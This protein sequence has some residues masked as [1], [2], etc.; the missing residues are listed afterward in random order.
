MFEKNTISQS[1]IDAVNNVLENSNSVL[2]EKVDVKKR[3][4]DTLAG[5]VKIPASSGDNEHTAFKVELNAEEVELDEVLDT[6]AK[7]TEYLEKSAKKRAELTPQASLDKPDIMR[8]IRKSFAGTHKVL[9]KS[10]SEGLDEENKLD[11][12]SMDVP[13]L[14][15]LMEYAKEDAKSDMDLHKVAERLTSLSAS[16]DTLSMEDYDQIVSSIKEA[17]GGFGS[18]YSKSEKEAEI[19]YDHDGEKEQSPTKKTYNGY[20]KEVRTPKMVGMH[21]Y[22][23]P[24]EHEDLARSVGLKQTK[25]GKWALTKYDTSGATHDSNKMKADVRLKQKGT[26]W[27]P[28]KLKVEGKRPEYDSVPFVT[29]EVAPTTVGRLKKQLVKTPLGCE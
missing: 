26:W 1:M 10:V 7:R 11:V 23:V 17:V 20:G 4:T 15:R 13:L 5:R 12:I 24:K 14:I 22:N 3:T 18:S 2:T 6:S 19:G 27:E 29:N 28:K 25:A 16:G 8:K 9:D 21:F